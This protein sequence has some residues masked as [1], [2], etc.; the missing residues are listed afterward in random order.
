MRH[1]LFS[2]YLSSQVRQERLEYRTLIL[3]QPTNAQYAFILN[4]L[5]G[6]IVAQSMFSPRRS[7][8]N[9]PLPSLEKWSD[10]TWRCWRF[11]HSPSNPNPLGYRT[12]DFKGHFPTPGRSAPPGWLNEVPTN[13]DFAERMWQ[14]LNYIVIQNIKS[15]QEAHEV[16][17]YCM[18]GY[19]D[20]DD[21]PV[22]VN[23]RVPLW[24]D[25]LTFKIGNM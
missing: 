17:S 22:Y 16:I 10:V 12:T 5:D 24:D 18:D 21:F 15:P 3:P 14:W 4:P 13:K 11:L 6:V 19:T 23:G 20:R 8:P 25:E 9:Q 2:R 7:R 1:S